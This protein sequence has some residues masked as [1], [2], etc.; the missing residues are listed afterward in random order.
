MNR[1]RFFAKKNLGGTWSVIDRSDGKIAEIRGVLL[2]GLGQELALDM[3]QL[4][5]LEDRNERPE[6]Q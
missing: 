3:V 5:L 1:A 2:V 6:S 4:L